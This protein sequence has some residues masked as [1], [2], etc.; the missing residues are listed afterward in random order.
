[1]WVTVEW[2]GLLFL[3]L[4]GNIQGLFRSS[5]LQLLSECEGHRT[6]MVLSLGRFISR[7]RRKLSCAP[8]LLSQLLVLLEF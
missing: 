5:A 2:Q 6:S 4:E 7:L 3:S 1:M 8:G